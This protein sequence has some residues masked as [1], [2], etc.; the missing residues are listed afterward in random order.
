[1]F[2]QSADSACKVCSRQPEPR[3]PRGSCGALLRWAALALAIPCLAGCKTY[4]RHLMPGALWRSARAILARPY[5]AIDLGSK[6]WGP[7]TTIA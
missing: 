2:K 7:T 3:T 6:Q 1:M 5:A 4:V